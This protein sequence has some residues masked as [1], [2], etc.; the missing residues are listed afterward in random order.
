M[1]ITTQHSGNKQFV[2]KE[3]CQQGNISAAFKTGYFFIIIICFSGHDLAAVSKKRRQDAA[4][5]PSP[6]GAQPVLQASHAPVSLCS[7]CTGGNNPVLA[8]QQITG[9]R[10][11]FSGSDLTNAKKHRA[12]ANETEREMS[13]ASCKENLQSCAAQ[14]NG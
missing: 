2:D 8:G 13:S 14:G 6:R 11:V 4:C 1:A 10:R 12:G 3:K 7:Q 9:I 5:V